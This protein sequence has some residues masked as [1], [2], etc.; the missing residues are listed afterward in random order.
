MRLLNKRGQ[1]CNFKEIITL[2]ISYLLKIKYIALCQN[3]SFWFSFAAV[4]SFGGRTNPLSRS[5]SLSTS[6]AYNQR[7]RAL[8]PSSEF[9]K[10]LK[11]LVYLIVIAIFGWIQDGEEATQQRSHVHNQNGV[12][13]RMGR[14][15]IQKRLRPFQTPPLLLLRVCPSHLFLHLCIHIYRIVCIN[16]CFVVILV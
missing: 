16:V 9:Q 5:L 11:T 12:G 2:L 6:A 10:S 7:N 15:Q 14:R 8:A 3:A 13:H 4:V 1:I